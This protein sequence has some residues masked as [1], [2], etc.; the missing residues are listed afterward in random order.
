MRPRVTAT[1]QKHAPTYLD[2]PTRSARFLD[3]LASVTELAIDTEGA[4]FHRFVD[5]IYLLQISTRRQTAILDPLG[6]EVPE[7]LGRLLEDARVEV[8]FHDADY[9]LRLLHQDYGWHPRNIFD[10]RIAAQFAGI[11]AFGLAA[12]LEQHFGVRLDKKHQRADWSMRPLSREMLHYAALDTM[13]LLDLRDRLR[14]ELERRGRLHWAREEFSRLEGTRWE[15]GADDDAFLRAK[16]ARDLNP[17][18]LAVFR[19]LTRWRDGVAAELDRATFRVAGND[20][21]LELAR[22]AP[23]TPEGLSGVKGMPRGILERRSQEI[24]SAIERGLRLPDDELPRFPRAPRWT[25]DPDFESRVSRLRTV[26]DAAA[27]RLDLEPGVLCSRE[28]LEAIARKNPTTLEE[29]AEIPEIR[30][31]QVEEMGEAVLGVL[32]K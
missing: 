7:R 21:L 22:K 13:Y 14:D 2:T 16:G 3:N 30:H 1:N 31:W 10:T 15:E 17:R 23:T 29:L 20:T 8:V 32:R 6:I 19:E 24:L 27:Q 28:R 9:D 26:R 18:E 5:R 25:R 11:R 4:S 12:L